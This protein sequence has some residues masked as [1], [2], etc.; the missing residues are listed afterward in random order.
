M[1]PLHIALAAACCSLAA[2]AFSQATMHTHDNMTRADEMMHAR[3]FAIV[4]GAK[5]RSFSEFDRDKNMVLSP[6]EFAQAM[7]FLTTA[8]GAAG[9]SEL[10]ARDMYMHRGTAERMRPSEAVSLLNAASLAFAHVD[11]NNDWRVSQEELI[12]AALM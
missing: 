10:P 12:A 3:G 11:A 2:P 8:A 5:I 6:M 4:P 7:L 1:R 9:G